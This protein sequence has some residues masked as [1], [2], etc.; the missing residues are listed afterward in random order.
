MLFSSFALSRGERRGNL[1]ARAI[2]GVGSAMQTT[3]A[4]GSGRRLSTSLAEPLEEAA[5]RDITRKPT[6]LGNCRCGAVARA[7]RK[8]APPVER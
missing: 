1:R 6:T 5:K 4:L 7:G 3:V 2:R 8:A